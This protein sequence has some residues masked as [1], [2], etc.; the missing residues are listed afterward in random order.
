[1]VPFS[2]VRTKYQHL[3]LNAFCYTSFRVVD[4]GIGIGL[5]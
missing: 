3:F 1:M 4:E 5:I 2:Q